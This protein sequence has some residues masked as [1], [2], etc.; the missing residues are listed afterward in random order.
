MDLRPLGDI[1]RHRKKRRYAATK[2]RNGTYATLNRSILE[3]ERVL[4]QFDISLKDVVA[5]FPYGSRIYGCHTK[6]SDHDW[7]IVYGSY[8]LP[9]G[10][11]KDNAISSDDRS[12]QAICFSRTGFRAAIDSYDITALECIFLPE[13]KQMLSK[14]KFDIRKWSRS[15]MAAAII[16]KASASWHLAHKAVMDADMEKAKK[17]VYHALR[18]LGFGLQ[19]A[20]TGRIMDYSAHN[21]LRESILYAPDFTLKDYIGMRNN[22][23]E[24]IR[25]KTN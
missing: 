3:P 20:E 16:S 22:F 11:F 8:L 4:Q 15:E 2:Y 5:I 13:E 9:S 14:M 23:M 17:S 24:T 1:Q 10:A 6:D 19:L 18:I 12:H 7:V 25:E 21:R